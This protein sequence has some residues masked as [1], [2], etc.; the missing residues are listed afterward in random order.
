V[1][2]VSVPVTTLNVVVPLLVPEVS[3]S[4]NHPA[5][6][7]ADQVRVPPPVLLMLRV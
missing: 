4:V 7:L 3:E 1:P 2:A 5:S 6:S